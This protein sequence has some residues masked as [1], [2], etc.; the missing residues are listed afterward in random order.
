MGK[1]T[2]IVPT[3]KNLL[4]HITELGLEVLTKRKAVPLPVAHIYT[5]KC[6]AITDFD[7]ITE[8]FNS[9]RIVVTLRTNL[10]K[11][12]SI[13]GDFIDRSEVVDQ[14]GPAYEIKDV[15]KI[16]RTV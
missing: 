14:A 3:G 9:K 12:V 2:I 7:N 5:S 1:Y 4:D 16:L 13:N 15:I 10:V 6:I 8:V 11:I